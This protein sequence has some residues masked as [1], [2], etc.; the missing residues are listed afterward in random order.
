[1]LFPKS[2]TQNYIIITKLHMLFADITH[3]TSG[4]SNVGV[5]LWSVYVSI[6]TNV[7][8]LC[9]HLNIRRAQAETQLRKA[10]AHGHLKCSSRPKIQYQKIF[11]GLEEYL[12]LLVWSGSCR[13]FESVPSDARRQC[14]AQILKCRIFLQGYMPGSAGGS[15]V[16]HCSIQSSGELL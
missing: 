3:V 7:D 16:R 10:C 6:I 11:A 1:M 9:K 14:P 8:L 13:T 4:I 5:V 2:T 15:N 12:H